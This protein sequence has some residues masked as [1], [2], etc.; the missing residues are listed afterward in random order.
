MPKY[1]KDKQMLHFLYEIFIQPIVEFE[2]M[3]RSFIAL[4][5]L[6][7]ITPLTGNFLT[8]RKLSLSGDAISHSILPGAAI[9]FLFFGLSVTAI[10]ICS[11]IAGICVIIASSIFSRISKSSEESSLAIFYLTSL[12]LGVL[13]ISISGSNIDLLNFLFGSIFAITEE[14]LL[15]LAV[16]SIINIATILI[17]LRPLIIDSMDPLY[18]RSVSKLGTYVHLIFMVIT[19][20]TLVASFQAIGTLMAI[21]LMIIPAISAQFWSYNLFKLIIISFISTLL[22]VYLGLIISFNFDL[23]CSPCIILLLSLW[24]LLSFILGLKKGIIWSF[25]KTKHLEG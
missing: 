3:Q 10:T 23:P 5:I 18:F 22:S 17:I 14:I 15:S 2:F 20:M 6:S 8:L 16:I 12:S 1:V 25:I 7:I 9:G 24:Y 21:G 4:F 11:L 19:V 13:I